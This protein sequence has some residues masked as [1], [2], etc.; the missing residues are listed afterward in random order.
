MYVLFAV[1]FLRPFG[2]KNGP[3]RAQEV[4]KKLLGCRSFV[5][6]GCE[7]MASHRDPAHD[8]FTEFGHIL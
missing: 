4:F 2:A 5:L 3:S 1:G 8:I 6:T 7:P